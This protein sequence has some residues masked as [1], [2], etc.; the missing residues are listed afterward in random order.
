MTSKRP[1]VLAILI[2]MLVLTGLAGAPAAV[3]PPAA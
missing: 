3:S 2:A 1:K